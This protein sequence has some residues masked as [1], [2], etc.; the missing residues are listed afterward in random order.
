MIKTKALSLGLILAMSAAATA[1][2]YDWNGGAGDLDWYNAGNWSTDSASW[3]FPSEQSGSYY[4]NEDAESIN[5]TN[6]DAVNASGAL[7]FS[8][9][10]LGALA[11]GSNVAHIT[12]DN[13]SS[14]NVDST[15]W[16]SDV[17]GTNSRITLNNGS[18]LTAGNELQ[19]GNDGPGSAEVFVND[20]MLVSTNNLVV[21]ERQNTNGYLEINGAGSVV[22]TDGNL[23]MID[24]GGASGPAL[25][26]VVVNDGLLDIDD[27]IYVNDDGAEAGNQAFFTLNGGSVQAGGWMALPWVMSINQSHL[28]VNGGTLV[29]AGGEFNDRGIEM[30]VSGTDTVESRVFLNG[31][32]VQTEALVFNAADSQVVFTGGELRVNSAALSESDMMALIGSKIDVSG[33]SA[34]TIT[35]IGDYTTL[36]V[37]EP[38]AVALL[39]MAAL[40]LLPRRRY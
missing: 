39:V 1:A 33:A 24:A 2:Q 6:G 32:L 29:L 23:Y 13:G 12:L 27:N 35:T 19:V 7:G 38:S 25:A 16:M 21:G 8:S 22:Q 40:A 31:G 3:T 34:W 37:P 30:G 9:M 28:T 11:D 15:L 14:L 26:Q 36:L 17:S 4:T 18:T 5:I 20:S 10:A